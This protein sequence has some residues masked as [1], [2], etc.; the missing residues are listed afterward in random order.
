MTIPPNY[1]AKNYNNPIIEECS[2]IIREQVDEY[3]ILKSIFAFLLQK[4]QVRERGD[5]DG[6]QI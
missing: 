5:I 2:Y 4:L 6:A 3:T 1:Q